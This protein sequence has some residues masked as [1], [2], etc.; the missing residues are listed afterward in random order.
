MGGTAYFPEVGPK[1]MD[2]RP[3]TS[4]FNAAN[5]HR[6]VSI[7]RLYLIYDQPWAFATV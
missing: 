1:G 4:S 2:A 5:G 3:S 6:P 7:G